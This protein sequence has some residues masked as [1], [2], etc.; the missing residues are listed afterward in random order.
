M[1]LLHPDASRTS[2]TTPEFLRETMVNACVLVSALIP[3]K[4]IFFS[5]HTTSNC[6]HL[7]I[8]EC[9]I[10]K[11][12]WYLYIYLHIFIWV[13]RFLSLFIFLAGF[14]FRAVGLKVCNCLG[15]G[16]HLIRS[17]VLRC[18]CIALHCL[19][20]L[21]IAIAL[22]CSALHL[23]HY[24][25]TTYNDNE[26]SW[27]LRALT[28]FWQRRTPKKFVWQLRTPNY[29]PTTLNVKAIAFN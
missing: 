19:S 20:L 21:C 1:M 8:S 17:W 13:E 29:F 23:S 10:N 25:L 26:I 3:T 9:K 7:I 4:M 5:W 27:Q 6:E 15:Y 14:R 16:S 12:I 18:I 24:F 28:L 22:H 2:F 11:Y